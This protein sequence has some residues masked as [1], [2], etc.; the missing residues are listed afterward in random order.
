MNYV[1][2]FKSHISQS[3]ETGPWRVAGRSWSRALPGLGAPSSS[4]PNPSPHSP[5]S[6][7]PPSPQH[8]RQDRVVLWFL[9]EVHFLNTKFHWL[10]AQ[11]FL[12]FSAFCWM[13]TTMAFSGSQSSCTKCLKMLLDELSGLHLISFKSKLHRSGQRDGSKPR[14]QTQLGSRIRLLA[15]F[16]NP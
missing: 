6:L 10:I 11:T 12:V 8:S 9:P 3:H 7:I 5:H 1:H 14:E 13:S 15:T 4:A 16:Y 2:T